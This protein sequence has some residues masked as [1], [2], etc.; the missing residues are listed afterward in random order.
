MAVRAQGPLGARCVTSGKFFNLSVPSFPKH[1]PSSV[2]M[3]NKQG[4]TTLIF[5]VNN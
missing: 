5:K 4:L 2:L 3:K 1:L